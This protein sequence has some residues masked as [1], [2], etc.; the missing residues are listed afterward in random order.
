[1]PL[2]RRH[3][4]ARLAAL[5]AMTAMPRSA[6]S[7]AGAAPDPLDGTIAEYLAGFHGG[8]WSAAEVT[9]AALE[10]CRS[11]GMALRAIDALSATALDDARA[12]DARRRAGTLRGPLDGVPVFAK[13]IYDMKG[14]PTTASSAEWARLFP[15][16]VGR[17]SLE[18]ARL[19]AAGAIVLGK[20]AADDFAYEGQGTSTHTGQVLNPYDPAGTRT[21]GGSSAGSAV[22]VACGMAFAALGTD[23]GGSNRIPA[24]CT[25]VVGMKPTFGL[26]PRTGVIPTWP[27]LDTHGPLARTVADAA[28]LLAAIAGP[29][30]S[31]PLAL[32]AA[33]DGGPL[34]SLRD[35]ALAG[36]RLGLVE[37]HLPRAQMTAGALATWDRAVGDLRSAGATVETFESPVTLANFRRAFADT[38]AKRGDV[39]PGSRSPAPTANALYG[40]FA[41]R[42]D[43]PRGAIRR[44]YPAYRKFYD[45]LPETFEACEPLFGQPMERDAAG[46]SFA[47]SRAEV[48]AALAQ[49][50]RAAGVAAMVYPTM[51]FNAFSVAE[52]WPDVRTPLGFGNFLG[53]PEVSVPAGYDADGMPSLNLSVVGLPG[54]DAQ[55]LALAHAYERQSR[56]FRP[57]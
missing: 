43:D 53:L 28:L 48:V 2:S 13:S 27:Y 5:G 49:A 10:R 4:I 50:M 12:A 23:D 37:A 33:W 55:V 22:A 8:R 29:D 34:A 36:V 3:A 44:G 47:K 32:R 14:L 18:I 15:D 30:A 38:A 57:A 20:T 9:A 1:M 17:D 19:R 42:T 6:W 21:P 39:E 56:R 54:E 51:P 31:D 35:D 52:G 40:Y 45:V 46:Q 7:L 25:G 16:A 24:Q 11:R 41:G 26:V